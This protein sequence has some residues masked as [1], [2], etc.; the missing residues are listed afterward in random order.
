[1]KRLALAGLLTLVLAATARAQVAPAVNPTFAAPRWPYYPRPY[2]G[3]YY[4]GYYPRPYYGGYYPGYYGGY[5]P[6]Y[7]G[8]GYWPGRYYAQP[9]PYAY[10]GQY[11]L[12]T[13]GFSIIVR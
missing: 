10:P 2:Y 13:P 9:Y 11:G 4:P 1:M 6:G 3:G 7:W 12:T 8:G 5:Y